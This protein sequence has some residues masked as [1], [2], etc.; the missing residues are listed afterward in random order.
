MLA[1]RGLLAVGGMAAPVEALERLAAL[2]R[3]A[4][5]QGQGA[6]L[7]N[8]QIE[9]LGWTPK[10]A[11]AVL[12]ALGF[13]PATRPRPGEPIAWKRRRQGQPKLEAAPSPASPFAALAAL[14]DK[15]APARRSRR[16]RRRRGKATA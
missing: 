14:K 7:S 13:V 1:F 8:P 6:A 3:A 10:E 16:P 5:R 11:E 2:L 15:P 9:E 4:P 12:R